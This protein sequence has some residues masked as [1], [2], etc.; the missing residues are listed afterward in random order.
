MRL[1]P[2]EQG[3]LDWD[4]VLTLEILGD[5]AVSSIVITPAGSDVVTVY[6][7]GDSTVVDQDNEPWASWGQMF[8]YF[9]DEKV[10]IA[11]YAESGERADSFIAEG[12]LDKVLSLVR[13]GDYVMVEFGHNDMK[14]TGPDKNGF[15]FF[16]D[17]LRI[18]VDRIR[19]KGAVPVLV[20]P[21]HR[22]NFD[23]DG[24]IIETHADYP[25]GMRHVAAT[26]G[27]GLIELHDMSGAFYESLGPEGSKSAFVHYPAGAYPGMPSDVADNT[28]FNPF[29]AFEL[30][31]RVARAVQGQIP[32]LAG[33]IRRTNA[34]FDWQDSPYR[35]LAAQV[36]EEDDMPFQAQS[37]SSLSRHP[38]AYVGEYDTR[39]PDRQTLH[40]VRD[41]KSVFQYSIPLHDS[42]GRINEFDDVR[43]LEGGEIVYAA[44]SQVGVLGPDG[45]EIWKFICPQG[46][47]SHSCQPLDRDHV[48]FALNGVPGKILIWNYREDKLVKEIVVP[49][50]GTSTHGQFR[51]VRMTREGHFVMG[52]IH[53]QTV[54]EIDSE[55]KLLMSIPGQKAWHV[56]KLDNGGYLIG[57]DNR[58]YVREFDKDGKLVWEYTREDAPFPIYNLQTATRLSNGNTLIT[59]WVAGQPKEVWP[60]SVQFFEVSPDKQV[61]WKVSSWED[62]DLGPCTY[63]DLLDE[64]HR[65]RARRLDGSPAMMNDR[66]NVPLGEGK[67]IHPGRVSWVHDPSVAVWDGETGYWWEER[68]NDQAAADRMIAEGVMKLAGENTPKKAW[69]ALFTHF[70]ETHGRGRHP[71]RKGEKIAIKLNM[72]NTFSYTDNEEL[73]SSPYVTL[74]LLRSL[75]ADGGVRQEDIT[76]CEPSRWLTDA[77]YLRC[78]KYYPRVHYVDNVGEEGRE[79][80]IFV[81]GA[82]PFTAGHGENQKGLAQCIVDADYVINSALLKIHKGPGVTLT[83][84]NWYGATSLDKDWHKNSHNSV[85]PDKRY[86]TPKYSSFVDFIGHK[87][88]GG[89]CL[90]YLIDG[91]YGSRDVNGKPAPKW[92]RPPFNGAWACS[93]LL[94]QDP[95]AV[96]SVGQDLLSMEWPEI[97]ALSFSDSYLVEAAT[98]P[99]SPSGVLYDPEQ[100]GT[101]LDAPLGLQEHCDRSGKYISI[102]L[103]YTKL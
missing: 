25:D 36:A 31:R 44:M 46:T 84:K 77:L 94:S 99:H 18:F 56:D 62:P 54:A 35:D 71:Y 66:E 90:L 9:T 64:P 41:G 26:T 42:L 51:H 72:N 7:C 40:I 24:H 14:L 32:A 74:A 43:V 38:F 53:E 58:G 81:D 57:G 89:K 91:S 37:D 45:R 93:L 76:V 98:I 101:P 79:K 86:G 30:A 8:P 29:G 6:L 11:N 17:Q 10:S 100:D 68:W 28:H 1:K 85:S 87:D 67:G 34:S 19:E 102:D 80:C 48:Y 59:S 65:K 12:R 16:A 33:H 73:N 103:I 20:T 22:R 61:V 83:G 23:A 75:V 4:D 5:P 47:E 39:H 3:K 50:A 52:L 60:G 63:I 70:N 95:L 69:T 15:G 27:T 78:K 82:M 88:L 92:Q 97:D 49:T 13:P 55:G 96:D 21:T 2:R